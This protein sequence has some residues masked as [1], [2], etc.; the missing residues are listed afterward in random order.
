MS[1]YEDA[2]NAI[3]SMMHVENDHSQ[4]PQSLQRPFAS[5]TILLLNSPDLRDDFI[6]EIV[7]LLDL[8]GVTCEPARMLRSLVNGVS[9]KEV[10][11]DV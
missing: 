4:V 10:I 1:L 9:I 8:C 2:S 5:L 11:D 6:F 7:W 3:L